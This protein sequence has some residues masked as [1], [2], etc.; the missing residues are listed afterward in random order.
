MQSRAA[1]FRP[2]GRRRR[3]SHDGAGVRVLVA[4]VAPR[5]GRHDVAVV[6]AAAVPVEVGVEVS[7]DVVVVRAH[8]LASSAHP[9]V[10]HAAVVLVVVVGRARG[11]GDGGGGGGLD[12]LLVVVVVMV[13]RLRVVGLVVVAV[14]GVVRRRPEHGDPPGAPRCTQH[15]L[16]AR[17]P[18]HRHLPPHPVHVH[19]IHP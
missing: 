12:G 4:E 18:R 14:V 3:R 2:T 7:V 9:A 19:V 11:D 10:L 6:V 8:R 17:R 1:F 13:R 16:L 5:G 15:L